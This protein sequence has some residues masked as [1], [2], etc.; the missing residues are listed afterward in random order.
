MA[1]ISRLKNPRSLGPFDKE[2]YLTK[3]ETYVYR[4]DN[5]K[6]VID[7]KLP[8]R[9]EVT[10]ID[11]TAVFSDGT[12][13]SLNTVN[14]SGKT[15][16]AVLLGNTGLGVIDNKTPL[17]V[18]KADLLWESASYLPFDDKYRIPTAIT[19]GV[20]NNTTPPPSTIT[21]QSEQT[22]TMGEYDTPAYT[23]YS[24]GDSVN[25]RESASS[26]SSVK[27][28]GKLDKGDTITVSNYN[29]S[30]P[31]DWTRVIYKGVPAYVATSLLS[32]TKPTTSKPSSISPTKPKVDTV[33]NLSVMNAEESFFTPVVII[34]GIA[35]I[36]LLAWS[37]WPKSGG[38]GS[39]K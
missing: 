22:Q 12:E 25:V 3:R 29:S 30:P 10:L 11:C 26:A 36:G 31:G 37:M 34:S 21:S 8:S 5:G 27:I 17:L 39:E 24:N 7:R 19:G 32:K 28:L 1:S 4:I 6:F 38:K 15:L 16:D 35:A 23:S 18:A 33:S 13:K 9:S 20:V 14:Y 2:H